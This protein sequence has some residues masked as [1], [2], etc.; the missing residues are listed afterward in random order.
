MINHPFQPYKSNTIISLDYDSH[1][2]KKGYRF[3]HTGKNKN[4]EDDAYDLDTWAADNNFLEKTRMYSNN[5]V[6]EL[7]DGFTEHYTKMNKQIDELKKKE[8]V[9]EHGFR[10]TKKEIK[11]ENMKRKN[12]KKKL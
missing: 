5:D 7:I 8:L 10:V 6:L 3:K 12:L 11:N 2:L 9:D 4:F 1:K